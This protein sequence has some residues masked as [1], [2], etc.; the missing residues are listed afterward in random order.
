MTIPFT[1]DQFYGVFRDH[2]DVVRP[3]QVFVVALALAAVALALR[4]TRW[5]GVGVSAILGSLWG[6]A[7]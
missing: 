5:S 4:R 1:A 3:A 7:A 2:N 6:G